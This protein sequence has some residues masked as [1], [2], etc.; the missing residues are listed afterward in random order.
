MVAVTFR[1]SYELARGS[2]AELRR[3]VH[4]LRDQLAEHI[5]AAEGPDG[6]YARLVADA[7]RL[8]R[9]V[10]GL[11]ADHQELLAWADA[12]ARRLDQPAGDLPAA[13]REAGELLAAL[14]RHRQRGA[15]LV[16]EAYQTD[17]GGET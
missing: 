1:S 16:Y 10:A 6:L 15:D 17:L 7:P 9:P 11:V 8:T 5:L 13:R 14:S 3:A 4:G 2:P 12:L